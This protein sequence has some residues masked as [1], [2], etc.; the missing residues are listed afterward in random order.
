MISIFCRHGKA[1]QALLRINERPC[2][3]HA[4]SS[5]SRSG[6]DG[7]GGGGSGGD[8]TRRLRYV[9]VEAG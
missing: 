6:R 4:S 5:G 9:K 3:A 8:A 1:R 2:R 7:G